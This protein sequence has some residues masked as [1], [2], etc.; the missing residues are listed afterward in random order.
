MKKI[1]LMLLTATFV[2]SLC[3]AQQASV[4]VTQ[5][6][7]TPR[8][9]KTLTGKVGLITIGDATKGTKSELAVVAENGQELS[10]VVKSGTNKAHPIKLI[11]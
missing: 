10:F 4:P 9:T 1:F 2:S 3:F 11:E 5:T 8:V 6:V 7:Q